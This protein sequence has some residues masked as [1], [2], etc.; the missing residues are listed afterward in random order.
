MGVLRGY[1]DALFSA[2]RLHQEEGEARAVAFLVL[3][4]VLGV[5][6]TEVYVDKDTEISPAS[7]QRLQRTAEKLRRGLPV[8]YALGEAEF[9]GLRFSVDTSVLIPRPETEELVSL[10]MEKAG[11]ERRRILDIGTGSGCIA[12]SLASKCPLCS[13]EAWDI[14]PAALRVAAENA[15]IHGVN[16]RFCL[17]DV[18]QRPEAGIF[19]LI[20]SNPPYICEREKAEMHPQVVEYEP[21]TALYVPDSDPLLFYRALADVACASLSD[22]GWLCVEINRAYGEQTARL[23]RSAGLEEVE[24]RSDSF[25]NPRFVCARRISAKLPRR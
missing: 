21:S 10:V 20:V 7:A 23:F 2:S 1:Y 22:G 17:H 14:S 11:P 15:R 13:V 18:L 25:G 16:V 4:T 8:Q 9:C 19:D 6:R 12:V 24:I 3:Q 5:S